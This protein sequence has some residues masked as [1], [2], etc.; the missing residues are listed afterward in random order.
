[1]EC[2][3]RGNP[4]PRAWWRRDG[5][6]VQHSDKYEPYFFDDG[7]VMLVVNQP[8]MI[9]AGKY[10]L[11]IKNK[12]DTL[13]IVHELDYELVVPEDTR[14][15]YDE[16]KKQKHWGD[17]IVENEVHPSMSISFYFS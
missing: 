9:D 2:R 4:R 1:M 5:Q 7:T 14:R 12:V 11:F 16:H 3:V 13:E 17:I 15:I 10:Y 6:L 8:K